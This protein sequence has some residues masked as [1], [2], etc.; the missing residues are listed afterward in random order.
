M[1]NRTIKSKRWN[2]SSKQN[3]NPIP[4]GAM[5]GIGGNSQKVCPMP[6]QDYG[7]TQYTQAFPLHERPTIFKDFTS[8]TA[9]K[10]AEPLNRRQAE[11]RKSIDKLL[12]MNQEMSPKALARR[13]AAQRT[14]LLIQKNALVKKTESTRPRK[15]ITREENVRDPETVNGMKSAENIEVEERS[16]KR[17]ASMLYDELYTYNSG[18]RLATSS[19]GIATIGP[20]V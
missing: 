18:S 17:A 11:N 19:S 14:R 13:D 9:T 2:S 15:K 16:K 3:G 8:Q 1:S 12:S 6:D 4:N 20:I 7:A 5:K 10:L